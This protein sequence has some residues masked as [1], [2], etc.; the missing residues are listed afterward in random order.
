MG[1]GPVGRASRVPVSFSP[2]QVG[3][4][5]VIWPTIEPQPR[6]APTRDKPPNPPFA[7]P[8]SS[9]N[10]IH[11]VQSAWSFLKVDLDK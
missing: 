11:V 10:R 2:A 7:R 9:L 3:H 5:I 4:V 1:V 6:T 8:G